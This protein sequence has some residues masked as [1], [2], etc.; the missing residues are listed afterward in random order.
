MIFC[1]AIGIMWIAKWFTRN[2]NNWV[3]AVAYNIVLVKFR[4]DQFAE[5][6][7]KRSEDKKVEEYAYRSLDVTIVDANF[8]AE[9][10]MI[11]KKNKNSEDEK[12]RLIALKY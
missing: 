9:Y 3:E 4:Y 5:D 8:A 10:V 1:C 6:E 2:C 7:Q 12:R 11:S